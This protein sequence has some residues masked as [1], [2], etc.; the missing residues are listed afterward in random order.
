MIAFI[1]LG[2]IGE[3]YKKT[4]HN[5][6][7]WVMDQYVHRKKLSFKDFRWHDLRRTSIS[8]MFQFRNFDLPMVQ[9]MS[10]HKN[11]GV[12]LKVYTKLDPVKSSFVYTFNN[13]PG[14]L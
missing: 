2:N 5:A 12:L 7:F 4:K 3:K 1:G 6:G 8:E 13:T 14:F 10:G 11:P 9:L